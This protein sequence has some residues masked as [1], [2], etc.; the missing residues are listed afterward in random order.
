MDGEYVCLTLLHWTIPGTT[1][2]VWDLILFIP[3]A[4]FVLFLFGTN[5]KT[6]DLLNHGESQVLWRY[7]GYTWMMALSLYASRIFV[8]LN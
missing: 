1:V 4:L 3:A 8:T 7:Y 5:G 6:R 2:H